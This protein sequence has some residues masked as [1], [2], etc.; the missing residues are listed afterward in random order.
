[1]QYSVKEHKLANHRKARI[2]SLCPRNKKHCPFF[3]LGSQTRIVW[4]FEPVATILLTCNPLLELSFALKPSIAV[5]PASCPFKIRSGFISQPDQS[6]SEASP[7]A[8]QTLC[9]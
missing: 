4:S 5:I 1:M 2:V 9:Q 3:I 6:L 7:Q 8:A